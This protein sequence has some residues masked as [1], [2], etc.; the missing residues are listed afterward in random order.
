MNLGVVKALGTPE[1]LKESLG[2]PE[3]SLDDVFAEYAGGTE[4]ARSSFRET[5]RKRRI[6]RRLG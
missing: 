5:F 6:A 1:E 4:E 3:A 2:R